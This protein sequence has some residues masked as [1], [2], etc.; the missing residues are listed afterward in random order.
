MTDHAISRSKEQIDTLAAKCAIVLSIRDGGDGLTDLSHE[1]FKAIAQAAME[2]LMA[3]GIDS[4]SS[5]SDGA[6][7][8]TT[9]YT[10]TFYGRPPSCDSGID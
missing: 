5:A 4:G 1:D 8:S 9:L 6:T 7:K 2:R 3:G 10:T